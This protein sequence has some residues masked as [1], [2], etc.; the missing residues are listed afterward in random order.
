MKEIFTDD[1]IEN[2]G[3]ATDVIITDPPRD[4]IHKKVVEQILKLNPKELCM[5]VVIPPHT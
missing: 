3:K 4:G 5:S 2:N 1:F